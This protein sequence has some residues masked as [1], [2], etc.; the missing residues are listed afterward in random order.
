MPV[1]EYKAL[2][3]KGKNISGLIDADNIKN[4]ALKLKNSK[5]FPISIYEVNADNDKQKRKLFFTYSKIKISEIAMAT[6]QLA[7]LIA[8]GF[9][10]TAALNIMVPQTKKE[11]FKRILSQIKDSVEEGSSFASALG[12]YPNFFSTVYINMVRAGE[13]SGTLTIVLEQLADIY[14]KQNKLNKKI[15]AVMAYP[16][17]M[18]F[19]GTGVLFFLL[20]V[21]VPN[22]TS[23]FKE[24][25]QSLPVTTQILIN[26]SNFLRKW[27]WIFLI[28]F[29]LILFLYNTIKKKSYVQTLIDR[30]ILNLPLIGELVCKRSVAKLAM[31]LGSLLENGVSLLDALEIVKNVTNNKI[32]ES[33]ITNAAQEV[34]RGRELGAA[35]SQNKNFPYFA[36]QMIKVGEQS[37]NLEA[38]LKKTAQIYND[39]IETTII[40]ITSMLEPII[41]LIMGIL[42]GFI[43]LSICLP[44][45]EM[46]QLIK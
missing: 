35:L 32:I 21:I 9:P 8:A 12:Q 33:A 36:V 16:I 13:A 39:E 22:I 40:G 2:N 43:V 7:T 11:S 38:M 25:N 42:I 20:T 26:S 27:W 41:I 28:V 1:Y 3:Q 15:T 10:L 6:R 24:M 37:G 30:F 45:F 14:E 31:T 46:N 4:A 5:I 18:A 29:I 19:V 23:I 34:E 17:L 44:I